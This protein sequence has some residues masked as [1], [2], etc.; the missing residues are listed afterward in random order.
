MSKYVLSKLSRV[1]SR[2]RNAVKLP[3]AFDISNFIK[4]KFRS[5]ATFRKPRP[6]DYFFGVWELTSNY[7]ERNFYNFKRINSRTSRT[8]SLD[9]DSYI[10]RLPS[11]KLQITRAH[12]T[13]FLALRHVYISTR[14]IRKQPHK[15]DRSLPATIRRGCQESVRLARADK[16]F[17][18][19]Q[20]VAP[21]WSGT[22]QN[23]PSRGR[24]CLRLLPCYNALHLSLIRA[25]DPPRT[26]S[27]PFPASEI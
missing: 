8:V 15:R 1:L 23:S 14:R 6:T 24:F 3:S 26:H 7:L 16:L 18:P 11:Y 21:Q 12:V 27:L 25:L 13:V 10:S 17:G 4:T 19:S 20:L 22:W 9:M 5:Y 2:H